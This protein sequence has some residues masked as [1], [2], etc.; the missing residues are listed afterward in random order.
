VVRV[1]LADHGDRSVVFSGDLGRRHHPVLQPPG[2]IGAA[3]IVVVES[4]YGNRHHDGTGGME[5]FTEALAS[6]LRRGGTVLIPAFAVDRTEVVLFRLRELVERGEIPSVP[7]FVD[8]PMALSALS[9][10]RDA[11]DSGAED[12]IA[13]LEGGGAPFDPGGLV[14][15]RDVEESKSLAGIDY[16]CVIV[17]ASGMA[18]GGRVLHHLARL[19]PDRR[20]TVILPGYQAAGTRGR[21]LAEGAREVKLLGRYV[22][23]RA[24]VVPLGAFSIHADQGELLDWV[25]TAQPPPETV[26]VVH[27]EDESAAELRRHLEDDLDLVGVVARHLERERL[28]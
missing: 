26:Y 18:T 5:E 17:S 14:E 24:R 20:N 13:D 21:T 28:D 4:T 23:V 1:R 19:L 6:T 7:V 11:I 16:P 2:P 10:Y 22:P 9:V 3:D 12:V 15:V 8:S 27:G 25:A